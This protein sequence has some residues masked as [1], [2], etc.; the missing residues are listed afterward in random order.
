MNGFRV[1]PGANGIV[2]QL[3]QHAALKLQNGPALTCALQQCS[4]KQL[5]PLSP[6]RPD[7]QNMKNRYGYYSDS[8][9]ASQMTVLR[10]TLTPG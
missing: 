3:P 6:L 5:K 1:M 7:L 2:H 4:E 8:K 10:V 9:V